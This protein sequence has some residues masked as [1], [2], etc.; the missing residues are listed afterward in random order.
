MNSLTLGSLGSEVTR[1][2]DI[3][4]LEERDPWSSNKRKMKPSA[5]KK[6]KGKFTRTTIYF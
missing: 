1:F 5:K 2:E 3:S 4:A 6:K